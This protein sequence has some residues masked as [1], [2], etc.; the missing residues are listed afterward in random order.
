MVSVAGSFAALA[1][2]DIMRSSRISAESTRKDCARGVPYFSVWMRVFDKRHDT[3]GARR[4]RRDLCSAF[5]TIGQEAEF[6]GGK[7]NFFG[8]LGAARAR[9]SRLDA[10]EARNR[11]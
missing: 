8:K 10:I 11:G 7:A 2:A 6:D 1:S 4:D 5:G 9:S 3:G